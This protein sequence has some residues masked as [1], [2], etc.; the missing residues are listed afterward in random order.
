MGT[1]AETTSALGLL[2]LLIGC[3]Q[4]LL[5][6]PREAEERSL[7]VASETASERRL[8]ARTLDEATP[9]DLQLERADLTLLLLLAEPLEGLGLES[10]E[11]PL[12]ERGSPDARALPDA[13]RILALEGGSGQ[14]RPASAEDLVRLQEYWIQDPS[15]VDCVMRGGCYASSDAPSCLI[16]CPAPPPVTPP[17]FADEP[18][19][20]LPPVFTPCPSGWSS[21][22]LEIPSTLEA[23]EPYPSDAPATCGPSQVW[24]VGDAG[25]SAVGGPCPS[26]EW[27]EPEPSVGPVVFV[28]ADAAAGGDGSRASPYVSVAAALAELPAGGTV[29]LASGNY[30]E[31]FT[32]PEGVHI[33][34]ACP[35]R[36]TLTAPSSLEP[37][38]RVEGGSLERVRLVGGSASVL[39]EAGAALSLRSVVAEDATGPESASIWLE[40]GARLEASRL[41]LQRGAGH[42]I[43]A[44]GARLELDLVIVRDVE[45]SALVAD[46]SSVTVSR[47]ATSG[48]GRRSVWVSNTDFRFEQFV[49]E[50]SA[51]PDVYSELGSHG[52]LADGVFRGEPFVRSTRF[53]TSIRSGSVF[54]GR[55]LR[56]ES[57]SRPGVY[58][59]DSNARVSDLELTATSSSAITSGG[60]SVSTFERIQI[61]HRGPSHSV[62]ITGG[63]SEWVDTRVHQLASPE[64]ELPSSAFNALLA[65]PRLVLRRV[66]IDGSFYAGIDA[67]PTGTLEVTDLTIRGPQEGFRAFPPLEAEAAVSQPV[68]LR[69][70]FIRD[71]ASVGIRVDAPLVASDIRIDSVGQGA[72]V[73]AG[74]LA[75]EISLDR[76]EIS[77]ASGFGLQVERAAKRVSARDLRINGT[78]RRSCEDRVLPA[79]CLGNAVVVTRGGQLMLEGF[80]LSGNEV[81]VFV[82]VRTADPAPEIDLRDGLI[83]DNG[84]GLF[85]VESTYPL[86]RLLER[87]MLR[88]NDLPIDRGATR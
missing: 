19:Q 24:F 82:A 53:R 26:G 25:C 87:V 80:E 38:V 12:A 15:P 30:V 32:L 70:V 14:L 49:F 34:G 33:V 13:R 17:N 60:S 73:L 35:E 21:V 69:R 43:A 45:E 46:T 47:I 7:L 10:G 77:N 36:T 29:A 86:K 16:P 27:P 78:L 74:S 63:E 83:A 64:L 42:G 37:T 59:N 48:I 4:D 18:D 76:T 5:F 79:E 61:S 28:K 68:E 55:R 57:S 39:V 2:A 85:V 88:D 58:V 11:V 71:S 50:P 67:Q 23:C 65:G 9:G 6:V 20:P 41:V 8:V 22:R 81:G 62:L 3:G 66:R 1:C 84:V 75:A 54:E 31:S 72:F 40:D 56:I 44:T 52:V 51:E